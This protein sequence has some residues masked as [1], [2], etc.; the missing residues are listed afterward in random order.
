[1]ARPKKGTEETQKT[2]ER[3]ADQKA[4]A[5]KISGF[6]SKLSEIMHNPLAA[7]ASASHHSG[8]TNG[9]IDTGAYLLNAL[10]SGSMY[11]GFPGNHITALAGEP[12]TGKTYFALTAVKEFLVANPEGY[13][14]YVE[15][16]G[17][18]YTEML[19]EWGIDTDRCIIVPLQTVEELRHQLTNFVSKYA[20]EETKLPCLVVLDSA[21][22]LSTRKELDDA[23][24][25]KD[26]TDMTR[27]K[28]LRGAMRIL[29]YPLRQAG[30]P[31]IFTNHLY[32]V[33]GAYVPT[34]NMSGGDGLV[35]SASVAI[36]IANKRVKEGSNDIATKEVTVK[37]AVG[38]KKEKSKDKD[39]VANLLTVTLKKGRFT[40]D[41]K[42]I[43]V[44][45]DHR[46]GLLRYY[47]LVDFGIRHNILFKKGN[48]VVFPDG[49]QQFESTINTNPEKYF[50]P[51]V[52][53]QLE[54]ACIAEFTFKGRLLSTD[55]VEDEVVEI[56]EEATEETMEETNV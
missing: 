49:T 22:M 53:E 25:G 32:D 3:K 35:Y 46:R 16:E 26:K 11:G 41:G 30:I 28:L 14:L 27:A 55:E 7:P 47:G 6:F 42:Q 40:R 38:M 56:S 9:F 52:M 33:P 8:L 15:T 18:V 10:I 24:E 31:F 54:K 43:E 20:S 51:E 4:K 36:Y 34:K 39:V 50:T 13:V 2:I 12:S 29:T 37:D 45:L 21:G 44:Y 23:M 17:A 48:Y 5:K 1:M 19:Q